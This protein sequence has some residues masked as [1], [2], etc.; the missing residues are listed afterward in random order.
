ML[1]SASMAVESVSVSEPLVALLAAIGCWLWLLCVR[2]DAIVLVV[3]LNLVEYAHE[4]AIVERSDLRATL[5]I[6]KAN[7]CSQRWS[8]PVE[9]ILL[10]RGR[11]R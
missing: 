5:E 6:L 3:A 9:A 10:V 2:N 7:K 11:E 4:I 1:I 8:W